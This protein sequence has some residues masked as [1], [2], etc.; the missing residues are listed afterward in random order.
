MGNLARQRV[1][2]RYDLERCADAHARAYELALSHR[3][4]R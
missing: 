4:A 2:E 3:A 1:L